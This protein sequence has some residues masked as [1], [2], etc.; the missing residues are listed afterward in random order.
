MLLPGRPLTRLAGTRPDQT[1]RIRGSHVPHPTHRDGASPR[2][3]PRKL[4]DAMRHAM[5]LLYVVGCGGAPFESATRE[6]PPVVDSG[7]QEAAATVSLTPEATVPPGNAGDAGE[8]ASDAAFCVLPPP[9]DCGPAHDGQLPD[10]VAE[11]PGTFCVVTSQSPTAKHLT[12]A[13]PTQCQACGR[14]N[15]E[16]LGAQYVACMQVASCEEDRGRITVTC[17]E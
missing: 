4:R 1:V 10:F 5:I 12:L 2:R 13:T 11:P 9:Y 6:Q 15:C 7:P 3:S 14:F 8:D 16:C 17:L